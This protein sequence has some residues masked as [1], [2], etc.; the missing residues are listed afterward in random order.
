VA[1]LDQQENRIAVLRRETA[2]LE[3]RRLRAQTELTGLI[4][5]LALDVEVRDAADAAAPQP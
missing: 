4:E 1:E 5:A 2:D 3:Q